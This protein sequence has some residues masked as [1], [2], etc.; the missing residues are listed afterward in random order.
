M[1]DEMGVNSGMK[2]WGIKSK[3]RKRLLY[4]LY[5]IKDLFILYLIKERR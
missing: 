2:S 1:V 3:G 4:L 5:L